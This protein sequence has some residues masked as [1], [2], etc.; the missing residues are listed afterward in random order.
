LVGG[1][2][3]LEFEDI[4]KGISLTTDLDQLREFVESFGKNKK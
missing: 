3:V 2:T 1:N 4:D